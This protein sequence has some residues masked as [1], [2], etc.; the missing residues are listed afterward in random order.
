MPHRYLT[1]DLR[2]VVGDRLYLSIYFVDT[3]TYFLIPVQTPP[4]SK[5]TPRPS[6][7][8]EQMPSPASRVVSLQASSAAPKI[9]TNLPTI[10]FETEVRVVFMARLPSRKLVQTSITTPGHGY[11]SP[12]HVDHS[13]IFSFPLC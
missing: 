3:P 4:H 13:R 10:M 12:L 7:Y 2:D 11:S 9:C 5:N 8:D 6:P 1:V